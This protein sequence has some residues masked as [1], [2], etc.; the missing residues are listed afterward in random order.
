MPGFDSGPAAPP[1]PRDD[2][3]ARRNARYGIIFFSIYLSFYGGFVLINAFWPAVMDLVPVAG[4]NLAILYG[5]ALIAL[6]LLLAALYGWLCRAPEGP[7]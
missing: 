2:A 6:A 5:F 7:K 4:L 1:E 3:T